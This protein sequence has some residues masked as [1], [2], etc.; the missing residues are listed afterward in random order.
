MKNCF[1]IVSFIA[2]NSSLVAK[3]VFQ[4]PLQ[5]S[6]PSSLK[7]DT[8]YNYI[9]F[10][11]SAVVKRF[12]AHFD[13]VEKDKL[14][15]LHFGDS[16]IQ[17]EYSTSYT[18]NYLQNDYGDG[19]RGMIVNYSAA[20]TY[21]SVNY[22]TTKRGKWKFAKSF[23]IPPKIPLGITGMTVETSD[24]EAELYFHFKQPLP[25]YEYKITV[26]FENNETTSAFHLLVDTNVYTFTTQK[27][28]GLHQNYIECSYFGNIHE[29]SLQVGAN[30]DRLVGANIDK[31]V[32]GVDFR[33]YGINIEKSGNQGVVYHSLGVGAAPMQSVL[34]LDR[35]T[36][37]AQ[38]LKPD[39]AL[40]DFGT[41][42]ILYYNQIEAN[43]PSIIS[44][45][46]KRLRDIN[47]GMSI[48]LTST[49]DLFRYGRYITV[50][51]KFRDMINSLARTEH[52]MF[53]NWYDLSG[54]LHSIRDW[55]DAGYAQQDG[56]HLTTKG[57]AVKGTL[58]YSS[59]KNTIQFVK[60]NP[61]LQQHIV[62][63]KDYSAVLEQYADD[64]KPAITHK[65]KSGDT[66][67]ALSRN[68]HTSVRAIKQAN[69]LKRDFLRVGQILTIP[70][71][72]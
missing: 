72:R 17:A 61:A 38:V 56:I 41:N 28:R 32:D 48:I 44:R 69:G 3:P 49:Q 7:I 33:F 43:L 11:D 1:L 39:I 26:F 8:A 29:I 37:Q 70:T 66:L 46:I 6:V 22:T 15:I 63:V 54:G 34:Y 51:A 19:G 67:S 21:S 24:K 4:E 62:P 13:N 30:I 36:E 71:G 23:Q 35:L 47:P 57:Y 55:Y 50:A 14:V 5:E 18:R 12:V 53:W 64:F 31:L 27:L 65:V 25:E 20:K 2:F 16:H 10:Y 59:I 68:Y 40:L 9:Q 52:V 45:I 42:D 58:L 60:N